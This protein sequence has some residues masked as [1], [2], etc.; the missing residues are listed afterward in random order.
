MN[1]NEDWYNFEDFFEKFKL[2]LHF[3]L[4]FLKYAD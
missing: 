4:I 2:N 3:F 1:N